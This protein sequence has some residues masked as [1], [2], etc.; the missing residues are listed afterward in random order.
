MTNQLCTDMLTTKQVPQMQWLSCKNTCVL[1]VLGSVLACLEYCDTRCA[2]ELSS[3]LHNSGSASMCM[4]Q[5]DCTSFAECHQCN[6][7]TAQ[8]TVGFAVAV[9]ALH[10]SYDEYQLAAVIWSQSRYCLS[11]N[12]QASQGGPSNDAHIAAFKHQLV[13]CAQQLSVTDSQSIPEVV[14]AKKIF[15]SLTTH[16]YNYQS[17]A[18]RWYVSIR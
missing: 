1:Q 5:Q 7:S 8:M 18:S 2:G 14:C 9:C 11:N 17:A 15:L 3:K 16:L 6:A 10:G 13:H 12:A 4:H